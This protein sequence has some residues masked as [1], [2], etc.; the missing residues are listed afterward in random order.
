[1]NAETHG[2]LISL[3][4]LASA[5]YDGRNDSPH[6]KTQCASSMTIWLIRILFRRE[7]TLSFSKISGFAIMI[8]APFWIFCHSSSLSSLLLP[9]E[10]TAHG[11]PES[12]SRLFWSAISESNGYTM[13][14][15]PFM[16]AAG[17]IKHSDFPAPVG[18]IT[19]CRSSVSSETAAITF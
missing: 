15:A 17:N 6:S 3:I 13:S 19:V 8:F 4:K 7:R 9:P 16:M 18:I 11:V 12:S 10:S 14:V 5:R 1:M 2:G